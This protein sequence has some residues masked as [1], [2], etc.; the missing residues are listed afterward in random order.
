MPRSAERSVTEL[1]DGSLARYTA[2]M[3]HW[4]ALGV[5]AGL[6]LASAC[7]GDDDAGLKGTGGSSTGGSSTG[8]SSTGGSSTGGSS[9]GG[10]AG[11][12]TGGSAGTSTGGSAGSDA[13]VGGTGGSS[14]GGTSSG[15]TSAGGTGGA[16]TGGASS[17]GTGGGNTGGTGGGGSAGCPST[18]PTPNTSC[19]VPG[20]VCCYGNDPV[21]PVRCVP[22]SVDG[23]GP[24]QW[25]TLQ[26]KVCCPSS[27]PTI[28]NQCSAPGDLKCC[29]GNTGF[30]CNNQP[31]PD[32]WATAT[33]N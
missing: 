32:V 30:F 22:T 4:V 33:C 31:Q 10:N 21:K 26:S 6:V 24:Y 16:N 9:T 23:G 5:G 15:G 14:T 3:R 8:G 13:S 7:G 29:Y 27:A 11:T 17:G 20:A 28:G 19:S 2:P 12:A 25:A 1:T 18:A